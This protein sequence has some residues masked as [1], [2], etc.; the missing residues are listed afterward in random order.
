M[1]GIDDLPDLLMTSEVAKLFRV[2]PKTVQR[3]AKLGWLTPIWTLGGHRRY[4]K[5]DIKAR[6]DAG[7]RP[8]DRRRRKQQ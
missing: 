5:A 2:V 3:W 8:P 7:W 6:I 4:P 1:P